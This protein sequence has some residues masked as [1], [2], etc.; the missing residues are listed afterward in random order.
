MADSKI[1]EFPVAPTVGLADIVP[2]IQSSANKIATLGQIK[3]LYST[4]LGTSVSSGTIS[5]SYDI[6]GVTGVCVLPSGVVDGTK[7]ILIGQG[8]GTVSNGTLPSSGFTFSSSS[9]ISLVWF[10]SKWNVLSANNAT[11]GI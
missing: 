4:L 10:A 3:N 2:I 6:V 5:L 8:V 7:I 1:S 11:P 9:T